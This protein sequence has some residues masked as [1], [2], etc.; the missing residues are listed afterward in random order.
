MQGATCQ[1][2]VG[3]Y[4]TRSFQSTPPMQGATADTAAYKA[5]NDYF[6]PRPLCRGRRT[7]V[8]MSAYVFGFQ[9][10][11]PMQGATSMAWTRLR[12]TRFQSTPPMQGATGLPREPSQDHGDF[13]P[14]PLCRG[15]QV[16]SYR[17]TPTHMNFNPRP[18]CRGRRNQA[19][20]SCC[21]PQISIH[22]PYAGGDQY[23]W[24]RLW[25]SSQDFN[26]RP[27]CRGRQL[28]RY[29]VKISVIFQST[30]PMQGATI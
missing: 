8:S 24:C 9:S 14:R 20:R 1:S 7:I 4:N 16:W 2:F 10:T 30:P 28:C 25:H 23:T 3:L 29:I 15:R 5:K 11:P 22:A 13:N 27:L 12:P 6:N 17:T 26:P 18:L 19:R 21:Q